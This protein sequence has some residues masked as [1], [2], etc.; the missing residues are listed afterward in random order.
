MPILV[1]DINAKQARNL[2]SRIDRNKNNIGRTK[3]QLEKAVSNSLGKKLSKSSKT[4]NVVNVQTSSTETSPLVKSLTGSLFATNNLINTRTDAVVQTQSTL[5]F[6]DLSLNEADTISKDVLISEVRKNIRR[7]RTQ[8]LNNLLKREEV[9]SK[10]N[11]I[12]F[13]ITF[14]NGSSYGL[15]ATGISFSARDFNLRVIDANTVNDTVNVSLQL[16]LSSKGF[17]KIITQ[18]QNNINADSVVL[19]FRNQ[20]SLEEAFIGSLLS[21]KTSSIKIGLADLG[22]QVNISSKRGEEQDSPSILGATSALFNRL[23]TTV[24]EQE[25]VRRIRTSVALKMPKGPPGGRITQPNI[26]TYRT[27]T[28]VRS[29]EAFYDRKMQAVKYFYAP[30][31]Y[32]HE[33]TGR[34]PR[35]LIEGSATSVI[36]RAVGGQVRILKLGF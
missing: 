10:L 34:D 21:F 23:I 18:L 29:I 35:E 17:N 19:A 6:Q 32:V 14:P 1:M 30:N 22:T 2:F 12:S 25:L 36:Q 24:P 11:T 5:S 27:G 13:P 16:N 8:V 31:Y 3:K 4:K 28:F 33:Q 9:S 7:N 20:Y 26:L 15:V